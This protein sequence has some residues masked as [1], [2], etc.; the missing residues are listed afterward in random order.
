MAER[1]WEHSL[2]E[3]VFKRALNAQHSLV[4]ECYEQCEKGAQGDGFGLPELGFGQDTWQERLAEPGP[5][6]LNV[7][8]E[9]GFYSERSGDCPT[10]A[11]W[12][13]SALLGV[14]TGKQGR[15]G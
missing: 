8:V 13:L 10:L 5:R 2:P 7:E 14:G 1:L 4:E 11:A 12:F 15:M 6:G 3:V 9:R